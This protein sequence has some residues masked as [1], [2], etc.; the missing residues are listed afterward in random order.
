MAIHPKNTVAASAS[1]D[2]C[3]SSSCKQVSSCKGDASMP[4]SSGDTSIVRDAPLGQPV[5]S[6]TVVH[7]APFWPDL[8]R[9]IAFL[10]RQSVTTSTDL[11]S[12]ALFTQR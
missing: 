9:A 3:L 2:H 7:Y 8:I 5:A 4:A 6:R 1:N 10:A 12:I 11:H